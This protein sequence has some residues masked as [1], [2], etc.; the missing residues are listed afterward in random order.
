MGINTPK[1]NRL[2]RMTA[3]QKLA[4]GLTQHASRITSFL[5]D[6]TEVTTND[7][8][9]I[10][11]GRIL[12]SKTSESSRAT[13]QSAVKAEAVER[14]QTKTAI[15]GLKQSLI[16]AFGREIDTLADFGLTPRR[17]RVVTPEVQVAAVAKA[18]ATRAARHTMG[19]RQ[20]AA[21]KGA[22]PPAA[23]AGDHDALADPAR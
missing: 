8:M 22:V 16:V 11:Q 9:T 17:P 5:I 18:K 23:P 7:L 1:N 20:K 21:I 6:G 13:W 4:D 3:D 15:S 12:A 14:A 2:D 10:L 19:K